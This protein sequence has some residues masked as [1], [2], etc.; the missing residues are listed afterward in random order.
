MNETTRGYG[1]IY[2]KVLFRIRKKNHDD[3]L[4][5]ESRTAMDCF[6]FFSLL[7]I[8]QVCIEPTSFH[9]LTF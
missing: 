3:R 4:E 7:L 9:Y 1:G 2:Q 5:H 8:P 6:S